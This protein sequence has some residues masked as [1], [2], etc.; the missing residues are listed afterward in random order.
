MQSFELDMYRMYTPH[1]FISNVFLDADRIAMLQQKFLFYSHCLFKKKSYKP[2]SLFSR[3][4]IAYDSPTIPQQ[5]HVKHTLTL[6]EQLP[7]SCRILIA[8]GGIIGQSVA[9]HLSDIGVK[10][11]V[12]IEKA[13]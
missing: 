2:V 3:R 8:G 6:T 5:T 7:A 1:V 13:K 11:I 12:L 10:D 9:Y 4:L